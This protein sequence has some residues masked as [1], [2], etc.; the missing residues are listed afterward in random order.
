MQ[1]YA[2]RPTL[3]TLFG[4]YRALTKSERDRRIALAH[5]DCGYTLA[6]IG[7]A[8]GLHYTTISKVVKAQDR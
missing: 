2:D 5:N 7:R 6:A 4:D 3:E 8:L 1:R